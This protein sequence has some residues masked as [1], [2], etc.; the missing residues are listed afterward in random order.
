MNIEY[1]KNFDD[2]RLTDREKNRLKIA[3]EIEDFLKAGGNIM[4]LENTHQSKSDFRGK[5]IP[6]FVLD[7]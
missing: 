5:V 2:Y 6:E 1:F 3:A 7:T 4:V